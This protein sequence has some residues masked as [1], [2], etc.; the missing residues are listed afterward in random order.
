MPDQGPTEERANREHGREFG[1]VLSRLS[2]DTAE[3][4]WSLRGVIC[5]AQGRQ[6][7]PLSRGLGVEYWGGLFP[8]VEF[9]QKGMITLGFGAVEVV[10][11]AATTTDHGEET[12]T[13][14]EVLDRILEMRGEMV[15]SLGQKGDLDVGRTG[16]L[17]VQAVARDDLAFRCSSHELRR[18]T[19]AKQPWSQCL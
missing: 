4:V 6:K 3:A 2:E 10:Q 12:P 19:Y 1:A 14:G 5:P 8:Q 16:I 17:I 9:L 13:G 18:N 15:D 7:I 11:Q